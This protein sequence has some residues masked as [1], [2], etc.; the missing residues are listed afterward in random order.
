VRLCCGSRV[1][2]PEGVDDLG[3]VVDGHVIGERNH[4]G[5]GD[6]AVYGGRDD[7]LAERDSELVDGVLVEELQQS[8]VD[9]ADRGEDPD[10]PGD[11]VLAVPDRR[12]TVGT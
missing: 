12:R 7:R 6:G 4:A 2:T 9:R 5:D 8:P 10:H 3:E 1:T 11:R